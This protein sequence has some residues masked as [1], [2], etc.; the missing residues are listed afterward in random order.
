MKRKNKITDKN[1]T[2]EESKWSLRNRHTLLENI[3]IMYS[4]FFLLFAFS[5]S[6][7]ADIENQAKFIPYQTLPES[8]SVEENSATR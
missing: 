4:A 5:L 7:T 1:I 6:V 3:V 8:G 2:Y